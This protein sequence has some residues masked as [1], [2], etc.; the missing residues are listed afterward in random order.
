[1]PKV[2]IDYEKC[3]VSKQCIDVC[4]AAVFEEQDGKVVV[5]RQDDC[6]LC[7]ACESACPNGAIKVEE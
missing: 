2:T 1:M 4:P 6:T 7:H 5:A 3:K